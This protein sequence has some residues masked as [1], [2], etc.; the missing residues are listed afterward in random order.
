MSA[1]SHRPRERRP[2]ERRRA[3]PD[4]VRRPRGGAEPLARRWERAPSGR[5][6]VRSRSLASPVSASRGSSRSSARGSARRRTPGSNGRRRSFCR[7]RRC[8][9]SPNGAASGLARMLPPSSASPTS[10]TRFGLLGL[11]P[12]EHAPLL[13][14]L[15]DIPLPRGRAAKLPPE[16]LRRRQ[17]AAMTAWVLAGARSQPVVARLRG[18]A[19]G[20]SDLA[21]SG[22]GRSPSAARTAPLLH[23]SRPRGLNSVRH[24]ACA[25]TT[26]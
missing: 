14:P 2:A 12:A 21:R 4:A 3:R 16:E 7:T 23:S 10:K 13:A 18:P 1:L 26:V 15:V 11:D 5:G 25:R 8:T 22:T 20:R 17:L 9:R 19:L 6:P 24:G